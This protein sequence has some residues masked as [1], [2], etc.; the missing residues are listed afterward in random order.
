MRRFAR[1]LAV[2][3]LVL[4]P[5]V[6]ASQEGHGSNSAPAACPQHMFQGLPKA[7][8]S[9]SEFTLLCNEGYAVGYS[10]ARKDPLWAAYRLHRVENPTSA[11]RPGR[12]RADDRTTARV[13]HEDYVQHAPRLYDRGHMAPNH[14]VATRY[15]PEAQVETFLMSNVCPQAAPLNQQTWQYLE[16][17][18]AGTW[19]SRHD[20]L[21]VVTGPIFDREADDPAA[22]RLNGVAQIP[23]AFY[24]IVAE[25]HDGKVNLLAVVMSQDV[26]GQQV[27]KDFTTTA[28]QIETLTGLDFF[29]ELPD[30]VEN[31]VEAAPPAAEWNVGLTLGKSGHGPH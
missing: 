5:V 11:K 12:F 19:S 1:L 26:K 9:S 29:S 13:R 24:T 4:F 31:A 21:W 25:D 30:A 27:L 3:T 22:Q 23:A 7:T 6:V 10:E 17:V 14:A 16:Q 18:I 15:G 2:A 28:N 20:V 8:R